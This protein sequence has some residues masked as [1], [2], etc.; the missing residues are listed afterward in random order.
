MTSPL[1]FVNAGPEN[2]DYLPGGFKWGYLT[3]T[4]RVYV[5]QE[6]PEV[7]LEA[8]FEDIERIIDANGNMIYDDT[9]G[10]KIEDLKILQI[11]TD[12]GLL[13]PIGVGDITLHIMY[14]LESN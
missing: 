6:D 2:R 9:T 11:N 10:S 4:I 13:A 14:D 12:E 8:I 7:L 3:V 1:Y 5:K